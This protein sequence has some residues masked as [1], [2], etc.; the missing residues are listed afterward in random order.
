MIFNATITR[1]DYNPREDHMKERIPGSL[2]FDLKGNC[3]PNTNLSYM[4]P[5]DEHFSKKMEEMDVR[6]NDF[7]V[8]Y[9]KHRMI[10]APRAFWMLKTFGVQDVYL[11]NGT[12]SKW[13]KEGRAIESG[14]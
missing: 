7:I 14:D 2:W 3:D 11:L 8:V 5:S 1:R 4:M 13:Q 9:D 12:F 6:K 10:S